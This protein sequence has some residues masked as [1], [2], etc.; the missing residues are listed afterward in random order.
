MAVTELPPNVIQSRVE[1]PEAG[2]EELLNDHVS[3]ATPTHGVERPL[4]EWQLRQELHELRESPGGLLG[5][6]GGCSR[7]AGPRE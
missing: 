3:V 6:G 4:R 1:V 2:H 5:H 7:G